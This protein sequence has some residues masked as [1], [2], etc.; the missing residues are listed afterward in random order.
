MHVSKRVSLLNNVRWQNRAQQYVRSTQPLVKLILIKNVPICMQYNMQYNHCEP[1]TCYQKCRNK[2][3]VVINLRKH[4]F[5]NNLEF[6]LK[7]I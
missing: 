7:L 5:G 4:Y 2:N 6:Q 3:K 1:Y